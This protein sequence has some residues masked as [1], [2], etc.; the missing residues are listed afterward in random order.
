MPRSSLIV[1]VPLMALSAA[2]GGKTQSAG[3]PAADSASSNP[4]AVPARDGAAKPASDSAA[5]V[6]KAAAPVTP[7]APAAPSRSATSATSVTSVKSVTP[8]GK[9]AGKVETG[10]YDK[11]LP[12]KFI[13]DE[14]TGKI[15]TIKRP[16]PKIDTIRRP[17]R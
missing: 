16:S 10:D 4:A 2:C 8:A 3:A 9:A 6:P 12:P 13:I 1:V 15:D 11:A 14:K 17:P 5:V 7:A